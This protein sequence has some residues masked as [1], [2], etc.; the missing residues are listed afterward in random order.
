MCY[1]KSCRQLTTL[2]SPG[3][4][5]TGTGMDRERIGGMVSGTDCM[6]QLPQPQRQVP[7]AVKHSELQLEWVAVSGGR[8]EEEEVSGERWSGERKENR[9]RAHY[10]K[11]SRC[12]TH[13]K[14]P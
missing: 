12:L 10:G 8:M 3:S 14:M 5:G 6:V 7:A 9:Q 4:P 13:A 2:S 1:G 11:L